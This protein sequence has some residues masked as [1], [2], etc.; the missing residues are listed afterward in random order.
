[1]YVHTNKQDHPGSYTKPTSVRAGFCG[2]SSLGSH[3]RGSLMVE[4]IPRRE[5]H[6]LS[7][8]AGFSSYFNTKTTQTKLGHTA[9]IGQSQQLLFGAVWPPSIYKIHNLKEDTDKSQ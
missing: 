4:H 1:M 6:Y 2:Q 8:Q 3:F 7:A 5:A 9:Q